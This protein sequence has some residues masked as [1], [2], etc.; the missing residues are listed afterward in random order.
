MRRNGTEVGRPTTASFVDSG[1]SADSEYGY[2]VQAWD[3]Q[4]QASAASAELRIKTLGE[5]TGPGPDPE[6]EFPQWVTGTNYVANNGVTYNGKQ[7]ICLQNHTS[8]TS[9]NPEAAQSLW[10]PQAMWRGAMDA[11]RRL[12]KMMGQ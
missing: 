12:R 8:Q 10:Q 9:W 11:L 6:P 5:D 2:T 3:E 4:G 7:Y 1:L